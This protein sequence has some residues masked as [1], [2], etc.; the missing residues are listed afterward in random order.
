MSKNDIPK[1]IKSYK[2]ILYNI[3]ISLYDK[4]MNKELNKEFDTIDKL[5]FSFIFKTINKYS[6]LEKIIFLL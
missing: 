3:I 6:S 2:I 1:S 4:L 5:L